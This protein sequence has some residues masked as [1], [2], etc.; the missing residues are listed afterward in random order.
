MRVFPKAHLNLWEWADGWNRTSVPGCE[1]PWAFPIKLHRQRVG[2]RVE[3]CLSR[4]VLQEYQMPK[5][6]RPGATGW[7]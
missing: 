3:V 5:G 6:F 7:N 4:P 2:G 1:G